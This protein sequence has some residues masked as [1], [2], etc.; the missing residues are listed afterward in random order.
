MKN[1]KYKK[2]PKSAAVEPSSFFN[3]KNTKNKSNY[4][5]KKK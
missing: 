3:L 1:D 4:E 2:E 5:D